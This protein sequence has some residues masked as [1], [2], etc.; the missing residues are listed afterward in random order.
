[1]FP[2]RSWKLLITRDILCAAILASL[3]GAGAL[4]AQDA[5]ALINQNG[6]I[7]G[8]LRDSSGAPAVGI[9]VSA[10]ARPDEVKDLLA[11][12]SFGAL[13]ETDS[14]GRFRLENVPPGRYYI[15][16]GR[17]D[18]P[19][20]YPG[21]VQLADGKVELITPGIAVE[22]INF[23]LNNGSVGRANP[24]L[25]GTAAWVIPIQTQIEGGGKI[26]LFVAGLFP[27]LRL[28]RY[29]GTRT[30]VSLNTPSVT[31]SEPGY[32]NNP[33][34]VPDYRVT[35][36]NLPTTY[37][38]KSLTFGSTDLRVDALKLPRGN[39]GST[40]TQSIV[41]TLSIPPAP[42]P[43]GVRVSGKVPGDAKRGI[44]ISGNSGTVYSDGTFE[45]V[46]VSPGRHNIVTLDNPGAARSLGATL[47]VGDRELA[48][49]ELGE[50]SAAPMRFDQ[51]APPS[52]AGNRPPG[53]R[54]A[55][56]SIHG[57]VLDGETHEPFNAG[58]IVLNDNF[59]FPFPL[60]DDGKFDIP[61]L[62][63]GSYV[64]DGVVF[65]IGNVRLSIELDEQ[66]TTI[67]LTLTS[68]VGE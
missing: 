38:L 43:A 31:V 63:P 13:A 48:N 14:A 58:K 1:V 37:T 40:V 49:I 44:Y 3:L 6:T 20:Y 17:V 21:T 33:A 57:R 54:I 35:V 41:I 53:V 25:G 15:L 27:V 42:Q 39:A 24:D 59:G 4:L 8:V 61:S 50:I 36:E 9:R 46:G 22:G 65:G 32:L 2:S 55:P 7:A 34:S 64:L 62:L 16:A 66:D 28:T 51:P 56:V 26:P 12:S 45:F 52:P 47:V 19:T 23:V 29:T 60:N 30:D 67:E 11:A 68:K 18:A 5:P 10:M